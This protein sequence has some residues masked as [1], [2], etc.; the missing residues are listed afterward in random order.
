MEKFEK[1]MQRL[2]EQVEK[3]IEKE[4]GDI[5]TPALIRSL[6]QRK[7]QGEE[8]SPD[9]QQLLDDWEEGKLDSGSFERVK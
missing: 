5:E 3:D 2:N 8:L 7:E 9:E 6:Q 4:H 1:K